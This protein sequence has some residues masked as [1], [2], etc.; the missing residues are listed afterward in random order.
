MTVDRAGDEDSGETDDRSPQAKQM[1]P[2]AVDRRRR[3]KLPE[4][5]LMPVSNI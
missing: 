1:R 3:R 4:T 2:A 5:S